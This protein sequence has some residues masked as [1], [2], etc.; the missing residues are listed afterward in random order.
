MR[1]PG[2]LPGSAPLDQARAA[3]TFTAAH[4]ALWSAARRA[5]GEPAA[6]RVAGR[7]PAA[8]PAHGRRRRHRRDR[9]GAAVGAHDRRRRSRSRPARPPTPAP[10]PAQQAARGRAGRR[11]SPA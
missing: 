4:E 5:D 6:T 7:G 8:A 9:G 11:R 1:K 3:G 10:Q 2:A